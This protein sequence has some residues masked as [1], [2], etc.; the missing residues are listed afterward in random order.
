MERSQMET[1][2]ADDGFQGQVPGA[3]VGQDHAQLQGQHGPSSARVSHIL[4]AS[5]FDFLP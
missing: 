2:L 1:E 4:S 3:E 5:C